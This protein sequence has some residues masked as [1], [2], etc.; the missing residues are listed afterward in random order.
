MKKLSTFKAVIAVM[1]SAGIA[2]AAG[3]GGGSGG[4]GATTEQETSYN[5]P[6][7]KWD[8]TFNSGGTF[9]VTKRADATSPVLFSVD[10][11][12]TTSTNGFRLLT[13]TAVTGT[14]GP[15]VGD[16][17]WAIEVPGY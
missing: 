13:V 8:F 9:Q 11:T 1:L 7:S 3:C 12:W 14:G 17:A 5:G 15:T 4:G 10:G 6:G 16:I 2:V